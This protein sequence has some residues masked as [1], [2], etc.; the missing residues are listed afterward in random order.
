MKLTAG[1]Y[2]ILLGLSLTSCE[3]FASP[4]TK[5]QQLV[6]EELSAIDWNEVDQYPLFDT[7]EETASK[8]EQQTCFEKNLVMHL[9]MS[10]QDF[11]FH[12]EEQLA[13]TLF[14]DFMVDHQGKISVV[15]MDKNP[16]FSKENPEF[17]RIVSKSLRSLPRLEPALKRGIPVSSRF[18][19]PLVLNTDD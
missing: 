18:R 12:S 19:I 7:C 2:W 3:W 15:S 5:T 10:L 4:E 8:P 17:E 13:D 1:F 6:E 11:E 16:G 14:V 9:S